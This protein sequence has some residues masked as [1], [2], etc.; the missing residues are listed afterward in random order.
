MASLWRIAMSLIQRVYQQSIR[1]RVFEFSK[2]D[3]EKAHEWGITQLL[4]LERNPLLASMARSVLCYNHPMLNTR[5]FGIQ[6]P[7]PLGLAAGFDKYCEVY[8]RAIPATGWGFAE[9]G[10]ITPQKQ[11]GNPSVRMRRSQDLAAIWNFMGFNNPGADMARLKMQM[12][13]PSTIP[14]GL[15]VGKG[16]DT[17]LNKAGDD[18]AKVIRQLSPYVQFITINVSS[19]N[20]KDLRG[21]QAKGLLEGIIVMA[22]NANR[23]QAS[24]NGVTLLPIG[25]KVSPDET[26]EQLADIADIVDSWELA[27]LML[28]NSTDKRGGTTGWDIPADRG[29]VSGRPLTERSRWVLM[30]M[31]KRFPKHHRVRLISV[32]G[33]DS[34]KELYHRILLGASLCQVYTAWPFEGPDL[35]KRWLTELVTRLKDDRFYSVNEAVGAYQ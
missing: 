26:D 16:K 12:K 33:I 31:A 7:N 15:N 10:G 11:D 3:A 6:F 9:I 8:R 20:T 25:V 35:C 17:P 30:Q 27:F 1:P 2:D 5:Q 28:V 14:L 18:Y 13:G 29:G 22:L 34:A 32:G 4:R 19:P 21:P 23:D 24:S